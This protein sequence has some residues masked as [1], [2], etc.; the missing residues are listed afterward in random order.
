MALRTRDQWWGVTVDAPDA[1]E[2]ARFYA[3][4]LDWQLFESD[5]GGRR[6]LCRAVRAGGGIRGRRRCRAGGLSTTEKRTGADR[7][8]RASPL[9]VSRPI[10]LSIAVGDCP[11]APLYDSL[12]RWGPDDDYWLAVVNELYPRDVVD[13]GCG[14]GLLTV[15]IGQQGY[16]TVG[17]DPDE[18]MLAVARNRAGHQYVT[19]VRGYAADMATASADLV[20]MTSHV[21][22]VFVAD[23]DWSAVLAE[24]H[25]GLRVGCHVVFDMRNPAVRGWEQWNLT[26]SRRTVAGAGGPVE[27]WHEVTRVRDNVVTFETTTRAVAGGSVDVAVDTLRF[28]SEGE[29]RTSLAESGFAVE[30]VHGDWDASVATGTSRELIVRARRI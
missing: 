4:L 17:I 15:S 29:L 30:A 7:P 16:T 3:R 13:L 23:E 10:G 19:W 11:V 20:L 25:R 21:S 5:G 1:R 24:I 26:D 28:R 27:V 18:A 6:R 12:N 9:P 14:T 2:L 22:Q 8:D